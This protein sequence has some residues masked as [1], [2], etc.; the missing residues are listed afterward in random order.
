MPAF[1]LRLETFADIRSYILA[2]PE[3]E[4]ARCVGAVA[5]LLK[6]AE[7][8][9]PFRFIARVAFARTLYGVSGVGPPTA[10]RDKNGAWKAKR[11]ARKR[12]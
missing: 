4:Q 1:S 3:R 10:P 11:A 6:A 8:G 7:H 12:G 9:G 5:E 2:L